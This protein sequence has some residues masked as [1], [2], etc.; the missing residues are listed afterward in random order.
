MKIINHHG[1]VFTYQG[2]HLT[3]RLENSLL[4]FLWFLPSET[5][6]CYM[7]RYP[8]DGI[9]DVQLLLASTAHQLTHRCY[10]TVISSTLSFPLVHNSMLFILL[11]HSLLEIKRQHLY[12][13]FIV[14]VGVLKLQLSCYTLA[15]M[16]SQHT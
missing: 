5:T 9:T 1:K 2:I 11:S 7:F 8:T 4:D 14:S 6:Q 16:N 3:D 10:K 12:F 13:L 15:R